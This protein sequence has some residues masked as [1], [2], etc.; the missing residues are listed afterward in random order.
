[1]GVRLSGCILLIYICRLPQPTPNA[2]ENEKASFSENALNRWK[3][4]G[5]VQDRTHLTESLAKKLL[6]ESAAN[7]L[8]VGGLY[9]SEESL[10]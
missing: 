8:Q 6:L 7:S 3:A 10:S 5:S 4:S 9:Q 2:S 1:M